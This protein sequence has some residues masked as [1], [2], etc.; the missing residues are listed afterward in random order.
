M[1]AYLRGFRYIAISCNTL[2]LWVPR[3]I[4]M[5]GKHIHQSLTIITTFEEGLH[6]FPKRSTRPVWLGTTV[7]VREIARS[8]FPTLLSLKHPQ[9][10]HLTQEIIWRTKAISGSDISTAW[11]INKI[12]NKDILIQKVNDL[13]HGLRKNQIT[14]VILGCTE[15]PVV[16]KMIS[17]G[18]DDFIMYDPSEYVAQAITNIIHK[19][20]TVD[21]VRIAE[22]KK[23]LENRIMAKVS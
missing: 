8:S 18:L 15:L 6:A 7:T 11:K 12:Y 22:V 3:A 23:L 5:L 14:S 17:Q 20:K 10:Q 2:Q 16:T 1:H 19:K 9:L 21:Q 13:F 4:K